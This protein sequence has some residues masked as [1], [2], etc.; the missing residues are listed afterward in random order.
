MKQ[1][2]SYTKEVEFNVAKK[3][4]S[5]FLPNN[6]LGW[7]TSVSLILGITATLV[8]IIVKPYNYI[9]ALERR[10]VLLEAKEQKTREA[11]D[12]IYNFIERRYGL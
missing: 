7:L 4:T 10:I 12:V 8:S 5:G 3:N 2:H 1:A 9:V 11:V 6:L